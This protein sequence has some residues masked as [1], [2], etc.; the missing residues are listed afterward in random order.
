VTDRRPA[1]HADATRAALMRAAADVLRD[2]G[3]AQ[4]SARSVATRAGVNQALIFYH[5]GGVAELLDAACR[6][7]V[8]ASLAQHRA[9]LAAVRSFTE[10]L[11]FGRSLHERE[12]RAGNVALMA[13][14]LA[15]AQSNPAVAAT[16]RHCVARW[17]D[18]LVD[19]VGRLLAAGPLAGLV[20]PRGLTRAISA[21]FLGL[22]LYQG[23]DPDAADDA[24]GTLDRIRMLF[25]VVD[26]LPP[27]ARRGLRAKL[28]RRLR[29]I[30]DAP[31]VPD[32]A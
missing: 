30:A 21:S 11:A 7:A 8:E 4:L 14:L 27:V 23:A 32:R 12:Q 6:G 13:Q 15:G 31:E 20:S 17:N 5:F 28:R 19:V 26:E 18:E 1:A 22:E 29:Q 25:E 10:L 9:E 24:M 3:L 2:D 16:A